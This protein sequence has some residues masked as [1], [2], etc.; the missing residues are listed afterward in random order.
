MSYQSL[1]QARRDKKVPVADISRY[2]G[3]SRT[4]IMRI[5]FGDEIPTEELLE[6]WESYLLS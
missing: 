4:Q 2:L 1:I 6:K 5:E 3:I